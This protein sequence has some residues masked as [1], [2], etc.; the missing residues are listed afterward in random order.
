[1]TRF[2]LVISVLAAVGAYSW[3]SR[4]SPEVPAVE[5][6]AGNLSLGLAKTISVPMS[7]NSSR[8][9][10]VIGSRS[11]CTCLVAATEKFVLEPQKQ[12]LVSLVVKPTERGEYSQS[13]EVFLDSPQKRVMIH[14]KGS[15]F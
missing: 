15:V 4:E 10:A 6:D 14:V 3:V 7:N 12:S 1:M 13:I 11:T 2:L 5:Y 8:P 9:I